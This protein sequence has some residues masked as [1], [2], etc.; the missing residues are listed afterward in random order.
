ML[1]R[2]LRNYTGSSK[3]QITKNNQ[4]SG[5]WTFN[6]KVQ[7]HRGAGVTQPDPVTTIHQESPKNLFNGNLTSVMGQNT[8]LEVSSSYFHMHW[9]SRYSD[10]FYDLADAQKTAASFD[11]TSGVYFTGPEPTGERIRDAY[12]QQTNIGLTRYIDGLLGAA[13]QLKS[14]FENWYGWGTDQFNVFRD[15]RL[16]YRQDAN[17]VPQPSEL[18]AYNTPL[19]QRTRMRNFAAFIQ[20]RASYSRVTMNLGLRWSYY[21]GTIP[22]QTGGGGRWF[23]EVNYPEIRT[24]YSWNTLAPRTGVVV[25][26]TENGKTVAKASY[27]RYYEVMYTG[28]FNTINPNFIRTTGVA[29]YAWTGDANRN[30]IVDSGEYNPT[31]KSVYQPAANSI[32]TD[33]RD[34]KNDEIMFALQRELMN[35]VSF[36]ADWIQ[37]WFNDQTL[38]IDVGIPTSAYTPFNVTDFGPDNL[39]GTADDR[40]LTFYNVSS[41][42]LGDDAFF[43]TNCDCTQRYKGLELTLSKRM[44]NRWQ[45][46]GSYVWSRLDGDRV[47]DRT[48]PNNLLPFIAR[49]RGTADQPHAFKL[50]GSYQAPFGVTIGANYQTLSGL[51]RDR[52][53]SV[54]FAQG[55]ATVTVEE[56]GTY[57]ADT[58]NLLSVRGDK[59]FRIGG[60][61][62]VSLVA[63]VHNILNSHAGQSSYGVLTR[64]FV[65]QAAFDAARTTTSYFGR[66]QEI[67]APR[68]LKLG[69]KLDF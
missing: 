37:R 54:P 10:E 15:T 22:E 35:N 56:R 9:P 33:L 5:F 11:I 49:G 61:R 7:P 57:R 3:Y 59:S 55:T 12:R 69:V 50:L 30:G 19:V 45:L 21:D 65:N 44:S 42:A 26:L 13:H 68:I 34:P 16:R 24:P 39:R 58:L 48:D 62:R 36:S 14:G 53:L 29:T 43:H 41:S 64:N 23:P 20:D 52:S 1:F 17:G 6:K 66:V 25:K 18:F 60:P 27:S 40:P 31:P 28:E 46:L 2:S 51:P 32:D 4:L 63:E 38:D 67:V 8:F 47:L